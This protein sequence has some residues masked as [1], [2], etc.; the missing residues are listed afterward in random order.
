MRCGGGKAERQ[1]GKEAVRWLAQA[2]VKYQGKERGNVGALSG[3]ASTRPGRRTQ[4]NG[5]TGDAGDSSHAIAAANLPGPASTCHLP[6]QSGSP[7]PKSPTR[8]TPG[9]IVYSGNPAHIKH[10]ARAD[11][12]DVA[13]L[14][15]AENPRHPRPINASARR[16]STATR[17]SCWACQLAAAGCDTS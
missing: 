17:E 3:K 1:K 6:D 11:P 16:A 12:S 2:G 5:D 4:T 14:A 15:D 7:A 10:S 13:V 8:Q 9:G